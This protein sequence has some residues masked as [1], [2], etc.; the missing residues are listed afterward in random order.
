MIERAS[1]LSGSGKSIS[2][3][4]HSIDGEID[5]VGAGWGVGGQADRRTGV[6]QLGGPELLGGGMGDVDIEPQEG[7]RAYLTTRRCRGWNGGCRS[8]QVNCRPAQSG[9]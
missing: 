7:Q 5:P 1:G 8:G 3:H 9:G 6:R 4:L 2:L